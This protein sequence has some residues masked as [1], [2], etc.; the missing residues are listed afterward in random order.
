MLGSGSGRQLHEQDTVPEGE[1]PLPQIP[2]D[3][4][5]ITL[6]CFVPKQALKTVWV[7]I[8]DFLN[9]VNR[10]NDVAFF[11]NQQALAAYTVETR[12]I[13]PKRYVGKGSPLAALMAHI[14]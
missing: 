11:P 2:S 3:S 13:F 12:K 10:P 7:N 1:D 14:F 8:P 5:E 6:G 4:L 9:A